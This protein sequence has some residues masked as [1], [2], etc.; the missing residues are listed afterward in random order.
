ML[1]IGVRMSFYGVYHFRKFRIYFSWRV[2]ILTITNFEHFC[3]VGVETLTI[4]NFKK[5]FGRVKIVF[6][7]ERTLGSFYLKDLV[8]LTCLKNGKNSSMSQYQE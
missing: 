8:N 7:Y 3:L 2:K 1:G 4:K 6:L 5:S